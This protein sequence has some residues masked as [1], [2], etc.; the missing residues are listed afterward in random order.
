M[1][2][3]LS[4]WGASAIGIGNIIGAG[5]FVLAGTTIH[6]AGPG[7]LIAFG[8]TAVLA[9]T[10]ALNSAELSSK[11]ISHGGLYSFAKETMGNSAGFMVGWMRSISYS[12]AASAVALG[13]GSYLLSFFLVPYYYI[14]LAA[15]IMIIAA[16]AINYMGISA[17]AKIEKYLV[18]VT[19]TGLVL[20]ILMSAVYG[21]WEVSRF[22]PLA[23][24]GFE[25]IIVAASLSFFAYSGFNTIATLTP[26]VENGAKNVPFA[27]IFALVI[28]TALYIMVVTGMLALMPWQDYGNSADPLSN[29]L[30]FSGAPIFV[31][32]VVTIVAV[33][34]T[35]TVT[36][37]LI[38]AG[39]R[40]LLQMS[41]DKV[42]PEWIQGRDRDSPR[43]ATI[44]IG[45]LAIL[46]LFLGNV[47]VIALASNFGVIFSYALT[48]L[49]VVIL[50]HR[51]VKGEFSSPLYPWVQIISVAL[52]LL[53]MYALGVQAIYLGFITIIIGMMIYYFEK[54]VG[55]KIE[56]ATAD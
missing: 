31:S 21:K 49:F 14:I 17:V 28:S 35:F 20:F 51:K 42:L 6:D 13:F 16:T 11:I 8:I 22:T 50:R 34:A 54:E 19:V 15:I 32:Y 41:E 52:S 44:L 9:L 25:S 4:K 53:I 37:S 10:I 18:F 26:E 45:V 2:T 3:K 1:S 24:I 23:P 38:V 27:I 5:I 55:S 29:A 47:Q 39:S 33:I 12:I 46:A 43:K 7:A 36:V 30:K 48:G 56:K 40:T